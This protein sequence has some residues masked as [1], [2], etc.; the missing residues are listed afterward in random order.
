MSCFQDIFVLGN[1][2]TSNKFIKNDG[3]SNQYLMADGSILPSSQVGSNIYIYKNSTNLVPSNINIS[4]QINFD[5]SLQS[6]TTL[7]TINNLTDDLININPFFNTINNDFLYIQDNDDSINWIKYNIISKVI[8]TNNIQISVTFNSGFGTGLTT[9]GNNQNIYFSVFSNT[10]NGI[11]G[12]IGLTG[13]IGPIGAQGSTGLTGPSGIQGV[14]GVQG[15]Q[16]I[17]GVQGP[18]GL[19]GPVSNT[20][21]PFN[22]IQNYTTTI[23]AGTKSWYYICLI[24]RATIIS[25]VQ[26]YLSS[27]GSDPYRVGIY[28][29]YITSSSGSMTL[30]GQ[31][32]S[33]I[34]TSLM[35]YNRATITAIS[36]QN[37]NFAVGEYMTIAF[38]TSGTTSVFL[39]S[40]VA[41]SSLTNFSFTSISN[42]ATTSFPATLSSTAVSVVNNQKMCFE[43]Y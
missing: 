28:R 14:Q 42:Y 22:P 2:Y 36:G 1:V 27:A 16:G 41:T 40:Q 20:G 30:V 6:N 7:V 32:L 4:G 43:L 10:S 5:T 33:K 11:Q 21:Y 18:T 19:T 3:T 39:C 12:P 8:N 23:P 17:Q 26:F 13:P 35:P 15:V 29:G 25:G 34:G 38:H 37:L 9:F 24:S 31:T